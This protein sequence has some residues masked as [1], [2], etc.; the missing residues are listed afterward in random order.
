METSILPIISTNPKPKNNRLRRAH[1]PNTTPV[2]N[3]FF[4]FILANNEISHELRSVFLYL[5][6]KTIGWNNQYERQTLDQIQRGATV[7]RNVALRAIQV[8]CDCWGL[9]K[10]TP[11]RG[12]LQ[13]TF[14]VADPVA[15]DKDVLSERRNWVKMVYKSD[16]PTLE[17]LRVCPCTRDVIEEGKRCWEAREQVMEER[18]QTRELREAGIAD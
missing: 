2:P 15:W 11:G 16:T 12:K 4:D 14:E 13:T 3:W 17:E 5:I 9:W 6:R 1:L 8:F 7:S 18:E 10:R